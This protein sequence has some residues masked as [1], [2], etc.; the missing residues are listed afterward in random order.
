MD[1]EQRHEAR[2][3]ARRLHAFVRRGTWHEAA[4]E[5]TSRVPHDTL[6]GSWT[7]KRSLPLERDVSLRPR[8]TS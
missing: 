8:T 4:H 1:A 2:M 3:V 6:E 5:R 7:S